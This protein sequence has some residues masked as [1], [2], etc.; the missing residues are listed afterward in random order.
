MMKII[1]VIAMGVA[2]FWVCTMGM[3]GE[4][5]LLGRPFP[6]AESAG[7]IPIPFSIGMAKEIGDQAKLTSARWLVFD[8]GGWGECLDLGDVVFPEPRTYRVYLKSGVGFPK[9]AKFHSNG[10]LLEM[11]RMVTNL[12]R[13]GE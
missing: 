5:E 9:G 12:L 6:E 8:N 11:D 10:F 4:V 13:K 7:E 1:I 3:A 2:L